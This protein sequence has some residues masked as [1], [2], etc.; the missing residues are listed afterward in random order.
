RGSPSALRL[1]R[2]A[3]GHLSSTADRVRPPQPHLYFVEQA[4]AVA[5]GSTESGPRLG[6]SAH[7][8]DFRT[9][10]PRLHTG[11]DTQFLPARGCIEDKWHHRTRPSRIFSSRGFE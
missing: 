1:V 6:R 11:G 2:P 9:S 4:E 10:P 5:T 8:Y 7:A 3:V